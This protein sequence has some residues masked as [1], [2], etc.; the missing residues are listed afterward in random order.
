MRIVAVSD[1]HGD[2]RGL[3]AV[4]AKLGASAQMIVHLGDGAD[5]LEAA[6][7]YGSIMPPCQAVC[8]NMDEAGAHPLL[9]QVWAYD[10]KLLLAHGH[11]YLTGDSYAPM[12]AAAKREGAE[13]FLFGHTHLPF[14]E[15][16]QGVLLI[17]PGSLSKPRGSYGPSFAVLEI[18][19]SGMGPIE[20]KMYELSGGLSRPRFRSIRP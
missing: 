13:A 17:N 2:P 10:R 12:V 18:P 5:D 8:G 11:R 6:R 4:L 20:V 1:T 16:I 15:E 14:W 19:P 3:V 7:R 9:R